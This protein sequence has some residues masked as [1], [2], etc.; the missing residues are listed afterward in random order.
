M[1]NPHGE[2][3]GYH[4]NGLPSFKRF[5]NLGVKEGNWELINLNNQFTSSKNYKNGVLHGESLEMY[6]NGYPKSVSH[7]KGW[8]IRWQTE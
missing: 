4:S 1:V 7:H 8:T 2:E 5:W 3:I 6:D